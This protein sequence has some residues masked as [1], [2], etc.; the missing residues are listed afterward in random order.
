MRERK[1]RKER[2]EPGK[3]YH[4]RNSIGREKLITSG[5]TNELAYTL[6]TEYTCSIAKALWLAEW[7]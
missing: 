6:W 1:N 4:V 2:G 5:R 3:I 7:G